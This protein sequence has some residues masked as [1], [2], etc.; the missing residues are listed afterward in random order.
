MP[1]SQTPEVVDA[2]AVAADLTKV[3]GFV[4]KHGS[5]PMVEFAERYDLS[6]TQLKAVF[7]LVNA[8][9]PLSIGG[10]AELSG[11]SLPATGRAVDGLVG[12]GLVDRKEDPTDRRVKLVQ[13]TEL[14]E[15]AV[16]AIYAVRQQFLQ[17][18]VAQLDPSAAQQLADLVGQLLDVA[19]SREVE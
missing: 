14:G 11:G 6:F 17:E 12:H 2:A 15:R 8:Q 1:T 10:L 16:Q 19:T 4:M 18:L 9:E 3:F 5:T 7:V 13:I